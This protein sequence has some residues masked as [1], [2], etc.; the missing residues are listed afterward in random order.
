MTTNKL[1]QN[2]NIHTKVTQLL[3]FIKT[4]NILHCVKPISLTMCYSISIEYSI[5]LIPVSPQRNIAR[6]QH[7]WRRPWYVVTGIVTV[8]SGKG[9]IAGV[10]H[11]RVQGS[12]PQRWNI[13]VVSKHKWKN[14]EM[15]LVD[16]VFI[17]TL[18]V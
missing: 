15:E 4:I 1:Q 18:N 11:G 14:E 2:E 6:E 10:D 9:P 17:E 5:L 3:K 7:R 16:H 8:A 13:L 12:R